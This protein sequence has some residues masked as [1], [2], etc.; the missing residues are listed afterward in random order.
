MWV[1]LS[2]L[3]THNSLSSTHILA[4]C[5]CALQPRIGQE[6]CEPDSQWEC[7]RCAGHSAMEKEERKKS[8]EN[9]PRKQR[10]RPQPQNQAE[11][12]NKLVLP[13][14]VSHVH[15]YNLKTS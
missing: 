1:V 7:P 5:C 11:E 2:P 13:Y 3:L 6:F 10:P 15:S 12:N 14:D 8:R 4:S 9:S